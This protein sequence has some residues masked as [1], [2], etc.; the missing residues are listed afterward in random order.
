M[1]LYKLTDEF[2]A[3]MECDSDEVTAAL[4][5]IAA[6]EIEAKTEGY[7]KFLA[8]MESN[9]EQF[10]AEEKR[11]AGARKAME[12]TV[13]RSR[14]YMKQALLN[15]NIDKI[16][17]GTFK[18]SV[19]MTSGSL[20]IDRPLEVPA[21]YVTIIPEQHIPDKA[22]IKAAIKAGEPCDYAHIEA[23]TALRIR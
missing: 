20:V 14:E 10:K 3:L 5:E 21:R 13:E 17:C 2:N 7:C 11:I 1:N 19:S 18:V 8:V 9:I 22:A 12:N 4:V 16:T 6:G 23:N 15:A